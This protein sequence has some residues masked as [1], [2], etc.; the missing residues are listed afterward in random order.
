ME[1]T[2]KRSQAMIDEAWVRMNW[3]QVSRLGG[4]RRFSATIRRMLVVE[5]S[6]PSFLSSPLRRQ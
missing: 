5:I 4:G 6:A 2:V 3:R 1:S